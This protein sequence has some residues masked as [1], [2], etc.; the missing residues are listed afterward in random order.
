[1]IQ[2]FSLFKVWKIKYASLLANSLHHQKRKKNYA[3]PFQEKKKKIIILILT[4]K[5]E[6]RKCS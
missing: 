2:I 3:S 4:V 6:A 5:L 1:M